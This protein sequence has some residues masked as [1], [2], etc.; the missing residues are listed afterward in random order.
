MEELE[1]KMAS[2]QLGSATQ[3]AKDIKGF[4]VLVKQVSCDN[5]D[6]LRQMG[7]QMRDKLGGI[8]VLAAPMGEGKISILAM[9]SKEAVA[10]GFHAGKVVKEVAGVMG[11]GGGGRPDM[12]QAGGKDLSKLPAALDRAWEIIPQLLK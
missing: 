3:D 11:G 7:D 2:S 9:A 5:V 4:K 10:K 8:V 12:A 1:Q 6:A